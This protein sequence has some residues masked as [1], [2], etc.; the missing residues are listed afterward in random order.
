M[1]KML[2]VVMLLALAAPLAAK[3]SLGVF[4]GWGAFRDATV[5][6]CYAIAMPA[7]SRAARD[8]EP[9][10]TI[11]TWPKHGIRG[12]VHFRLSRQLAKGARISLQIGR[13][14]FRLTGGGA[15]AWSAD[16]RM[17]AAIVA[18]MRSATS[19]ALSAT[20]SAGRRFTNSYSL[21][22]AATAMDAAT[23]ACS[24]SSR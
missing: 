22:G 10:A 18:A 12:Q 20:D 21:G 4:S 6:R 7:A 17:D 24:R 16:R 5:P 15:D 19:M 11:A 14:S 2:P 9:F 8:F 13:Q 1:R 23:V 3:D